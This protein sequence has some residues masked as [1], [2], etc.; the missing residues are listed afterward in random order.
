MMDL[1]KDFRQ[2]LFQ[3]FPVGGGGFPSAAE[4]QDVRDFVGFE[5][6]RGEDVRGLFL[7]G[8]AGGAGAHGKAGFVEA[9][10]PTLL[11]AFG[12]ERRSGVPQTRRAK[13]HNG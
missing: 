10:H 11:A 2:T 6:H 7:A 12:H 9:R 4:A 1:G 3:R 8:R 13:A 5:A